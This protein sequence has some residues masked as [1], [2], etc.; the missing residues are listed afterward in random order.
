M[1]I[2]ETKIFKIDPRKPDKLL[3]AEAAR[4]IQ[5]G[6]IVAFPTE[7]VYGIGANALDSDAVARIFAAKG[8][9]R[10]NP[11]IVHVAGN[12]W[13]E[14]IAIDVPSIA[15]KLMGWFWPGPLTLVLKKGPRIP[16]E[17]TAG[18]GTVAVRAPLHRIALE[19]IRE[20][21][22][23]VAAPS[24]NVSGKPSPTNAQ[25][26]IDDLF[27]KVDVII[28]G[29]R[30]QIGIESTVLDL[31]VPEPMILRPGGVTREQLDEA[32][33]GVGGEDKQEAKIFSF[34]GITKPESVS[35]P[36]KSPGI[37]YRHYA[38]KAEMLLFVGSHE[39]IAD[40]MRLIISQIHTYMGR[41]R[42]DWTR[43]VGVRVGDTSANRTWASGIGTNGTGFTGTGDGETGIGSIGVL[44]TYELIERIELLMPGAGVL[45]VPMGRAESNDSLAE[46]MFDSLRKMDDA[47]V[48]LILAEGFP[49]VG[50]GN[51]IMD[52]L[53]RAASGRVIKTNG[54]RRVLFVCTGNTCRSSMA[55]A[56]FNHEVLRV[57]EKA[58]KAEMPEKPVKPVKADK[59][60]KAEKTEK[61]EE[62]KKAEKTEK[63]EMPIFAESAG[64]HAFEGDTASK[65]AIKIMREEWGISL[66]N[67][68]ARALS[69]DMVESADIILT[70]GNGHKESILRKH[71]KSFGKVFTL[72]EFSDN[73]PMDIADPFGSGEAVYR[74]CARQIKAAIDKTVGLIS[75]E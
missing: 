11:L 29:G 12:S 61:T 18:L 56:L 67:H 25:H 74:N 26:V 60:E 42:A 50:L 65:L 1:N 41:T 47:N 38:P 27:G 36:A 55:E 69:G 44:A 8:R 52:R 40:R 63:P 19:L 22:L 43:P 30:T 2:I 59:L 71:P 48:G 33:G 4:I 15:Y 9:P 68:I 70:M 7:T 51:A 37:R 23:P 45:C 20:S 32:I 46:N 10:D 35:H 64:L 13:I 53:T 39:Q 17:V 14:D 49:Q 5:S 6:G 28:D 16:D 66:D 58:G 73:S 34:S 21:G 57:T 3:I 62:T 72:L 31:T 24:A 75:H 54:F